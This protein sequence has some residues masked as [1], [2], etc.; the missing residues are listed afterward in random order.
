MKKEWKRIDIVM[1]EDGNI[2]SAKVDGVP[3]KEFNKNEKS[4][5]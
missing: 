2:I 5:K 3:T 4:K 1:D